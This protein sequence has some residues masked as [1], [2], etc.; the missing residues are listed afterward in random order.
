MR[1]MW[2][3]QKAFAISVRSRFRMNYR[4]DAQRDQFLDWIEAVARLFIDRHSNSD[5][6]NLDQ[7]PPD[8]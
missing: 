1:K 7:P 2:L 6:N 5:D 3:A 4:T 8:A